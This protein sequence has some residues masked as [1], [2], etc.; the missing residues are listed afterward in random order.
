MGPVVG[1]EQGEVGVEGGEMLVKVKIGRVEGWREDPHL[2]Q[3]ALS[4]IQ[5]HNFS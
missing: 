1:V 5:G 2:A 4:S 3:W